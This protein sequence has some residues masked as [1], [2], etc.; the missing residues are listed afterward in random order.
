MP[1]TRNAMQDIGGL[2]LW[3]PMSGSYARQLMAAGP[4]R[5]IPVC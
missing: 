2:N 5:Q 4:A 3:P 1:S